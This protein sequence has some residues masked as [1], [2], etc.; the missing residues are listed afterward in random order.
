[1]LL[2]TMDAFN[3]H[4]NTSWEGICA[5]S[6]KMETC[7]PLACRDV[8]KK[9]GQKGRLGQVGRGGRMLRQRPDGGHWWDGAL[10]ACTASAT[11]V[12]EGLRGGR[13]RC[14]SHHRRHGW[15]KTWT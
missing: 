9:C 11:G 3:I 7:I 1:M 12:V 14:S 8:R 6:R 5:I 2:A 4:L 10:T 13:G 15:R